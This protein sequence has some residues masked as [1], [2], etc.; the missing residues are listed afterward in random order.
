ME[1]GDSAKKVA[2]RF[3]G[4]FLPPIISRSTDAD[5]E[6]KDQSS[7][8]SNDGNFLTYKRLVQTSNLRRFKNS[9]IK[10]LDRLFRRA[11]DATTLVMYLTYANVANSTGRIM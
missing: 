4:F 6:V 9:G 5:N 11:R 2:F 10:L 1:N 7:E 8:C 3:S